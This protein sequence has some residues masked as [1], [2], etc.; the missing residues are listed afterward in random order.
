LIKEISAMTPMYSFSRYFNNFLLSIVVAVS[1]RHSRRAHR[2]QHRFSVEI[3][4]LNV[5]VSEI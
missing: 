5:K 1:C 4:A 3:F 2:G